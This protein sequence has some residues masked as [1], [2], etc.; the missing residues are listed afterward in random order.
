M[1]AFLHSDV[2][3]WGNGRLIRPGMESPIVDNE[4]SNKGINDSLSPVYWRTVTGG[5]ILEKS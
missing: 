1:P 3:A 5:I 2:R 4:F